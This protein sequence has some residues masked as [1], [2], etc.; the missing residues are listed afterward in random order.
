MLGKRETEL[1]LAKYF[2]DC[3]KFWMRT[4]P[5]EREAF[6]NALD[7]IRHIKKDPFSPQGKELDVETKKQ[8]IKYRDLDLR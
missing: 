3:L 6:Q 2:R 4:V 7:D 1:I 8:F 5:T